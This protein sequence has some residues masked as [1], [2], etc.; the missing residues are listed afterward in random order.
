[1]DAKKLAA[2]FRQLGASD[3]DSWASSEANENIP[4]LARYM[5]LK[6]AWDRIASDDELS[7]IDNVIANVPPE[8]NDPYAGAAHSIRRM[9]AAGVSRTDIATLVRNSQAEFLFDICYM[10]ADPGSVS[11][12]A[13]LVNWT[14]VE[15]DAAGN[16]GR[17]INGLHE[18]V[19]ETDPT[20]REV[21]PKK[22]A[23]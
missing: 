9:I 21:R 4:Q 12:N 5:F 19:L 20:G 23:G 3:P 10:M 13:D 1:M 8:S 2:I 6:G 14:L 16:L 7:W 17:S 11:G 22:D 18:S 15:C